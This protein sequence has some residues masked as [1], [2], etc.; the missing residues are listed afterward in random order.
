[1]SQV[2]PENYVMFQGVGREQHSHQQSRRK[3]LPWSSRLSREVVL[4]CQEVVPVFESSAITSPQ[5]NSVLNGFSFRILLIREGFVLFSR[6]CILRCL[7]SFKIKIYYSLH[8]HRENTLRK[9]FSHFDSLKS[10]RFAFFSRE[11][12]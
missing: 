3:S 11:Y 7:N 9:C 8:H 5:P 12:L 2:F 10:K 6:L 4:L 1:M